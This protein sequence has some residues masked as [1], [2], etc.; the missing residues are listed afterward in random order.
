MG[1]KSNFNKFLKQST[2]EKCFSLVHISEFAYKKIA[3]D[4]SLYLYKFKSILEQKWIDGFVNMIKCM[5]QNNVHCVFILDGK[6]P[7]DKVEE[8][9]K[10]REERKK[11]IETVKLLEDDLDKY[12]STSILSDKLQNIVNNEN[13]TKNNMITSIS[14]YI[15]KKKKQIVHVNEDDF[16][17]LKELFDCFSV[18]YFTAPTEAEKFCSKLC[19]DGLVSAVLSDDTDIIAYGCIMSLSK[20]DAIT[21]LCTCIHYNNLLS[22]LD[23]NKKQFLDLCILCGTDYNKNLHKIGSFTAFKYI[24]LYNDIETIGEKLN[25]NLDE[26][27]YERVRQ[28]FTNFEPYNIEIPF[29]G[30]TDIYKL[31]IFFSNNNVNNSNMQKYIFFQNINLI[32]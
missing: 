3:I 6:A 2:N 31:S 32:E 21:G 25:I 11:L 16:N 24:K 23:I 30:K 18:P 28:L 15:Q 12:M 17:K 9:L 26:L 1:I 20:F 14:S 4:T 13:T 7:V 8:Q 27:P 19:I 5:R 29:C 22:L 10:R